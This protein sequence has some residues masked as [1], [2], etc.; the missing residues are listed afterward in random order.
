MMKEANPQKFSISQSLGLT[1]LRAFIG[2]HF[3]YE[4]IVKLTDPEWTSQAYLV[5]SRWLLNDFFHWIAADPTRV[6]WVDL[7]NIWGLVLIGSS[8][9]LGVFARFTSLMG[10]LLLAL[11]YLAHP[12]LPGT[13]I[14]PFAEGSYLIVDKN[15]VELAGLMVIALFPSTAFFGVD[16]FGFLFRKRQPSIKEPGEGTLESGSAETVP[17]ISSPRREVLKALT[18]LPFLAAFASAFARRKYLESHEEKILVDGIT[19]A[20]MKKFEFTTLASLKDPVPHSEIKGLE[21][22]R[23]ILGGNLMG[24]WAHARDLIYVSDFVKAYHNQEKIFETFALAEQC[25]INTVLTNPVLCETI[26]EYWNRKIGKIQFIS[27]CGGTDLMEGV[28]RSIDQGAAACYVHG[29]IAD[30]LV[31][32]GKVDQIGE[33]LSFIK[34]RNLP[35]GIGGHRIETTKACVEAGFE[36]DFWM[37]TLHPMSYWSAE[38][39]TEHD[40]IFCYGGPEETIAYMESLP[41]PWIAFKILAAGA[42]R[43]TEAF[44]YAFEHGADFVCVGMYDFQIVDD[45]NL[46]VA[47]L[48]DDLPRQRRW[49][50]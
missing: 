46:L 43:P 26:N 8:L 36:P 21:V 11:Y 12:S 1:L 14:D 47:T 27:D 7:L 3:L 34:D 20:T 22:S 10:I 39:P 15:L 25:G 38:H 45:V 40:N 28:K 4:G 2:W 37:K 5:G 31:S 17:A 13:L 32:E 9:L 6:Q 33:A 44:R 30:R 49:L 16:R 35:A 50:A 48:T 41:Q 19:S 42:I 18:S 23:L 24:G 29:G